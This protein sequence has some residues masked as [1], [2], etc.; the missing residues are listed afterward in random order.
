MNGDVAATRA[1][2]T[3]AFIMLPVARLDAGDFAVVHDLDEDRSGRN[4][5][6][7]SKKAVFRPVLRHY[8]SLALELR[9]HQ[10]LRR[11]NK[12]AGDEKVAVGQHEVAQ[13]RQRR[14][15][16]RQLERPDS[17]WDAN[18]CACILVSR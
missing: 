16:Y 17:L 5:Q 6:A 14:R 2:T 12:P 15:L 18:L 13:A 9:F 10:Q 7:A 3:A 4:T 1:G 11:R 8:A